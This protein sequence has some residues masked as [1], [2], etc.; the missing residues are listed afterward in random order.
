VLQALADTTSVALENVQLYQDLERRVETRTAQLQSANEKLRVTNVKL[1]TA[2]DELALL[3]K[4]LETF[5]SAVSHDLRAPLRKMATFSE[6]LQNRLADNPDDRSM[7]YVRRIRLS[8]DRMSELIE[9][10]LV[11]SRTA[12]APVGREVVDMSGLARVIASDLRTGDAE[13]QVEFKIADGISADCDPGLL[14][15]ALENLLGNAW[16]YTSRNPDA[17]IEFGSMQEN[18]GETVYFIRD[19]GAGFDMQ[20]AD[21]LFVPF[22][23]LHSSSDFPGTGIGL[24]TVQRIIRKHGGRIWAEAAINAGALFCFTLD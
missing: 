18:G 5:T 4:E 14:R 12:R 13:R 9:D 24:A 16:K 8:T 21:K 7:E 10:L 11:L 15:T 2:N 17:R 6:L 20:F 3:N 1:R 23:R 22:Q 19:N